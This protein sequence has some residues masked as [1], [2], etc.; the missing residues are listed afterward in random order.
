M[1]AS[2]SN[3]GGLR[4]GFCR[5]LIGFL[6][7]T[8]IGIF[9]AIH[10]TDANT[11]ADLIP[12][13]FKPSDFIP[14]WEDFFHEDPFNA[15]GPD[16]APRWRNSGN[17]LNLEIVNALDERWNVY[18][19]RAVQEWDA[20][21]PDVLD[22]TTS[23]SSVDSSCQAVEGVMKVCNGNY[24][25]TRWKGIN[26]VIIENG[27]RII[28]STAKMNEFYLSG[29]NDAQKQYTMCHEI[30]HGFG[31]P[32]TDENFNNANTGECMDYTSQ[33][34]ANMQ[35]GEANFLFLQE[36][37]GTQTGGNTVASASEVPTDR[38]IP[39]LRGSATISWFE[40]V[41]LSVWDDLIPKIEGRVDEREHEDGWQ[42]VH[43]S[44]HGSAHEMYLGKGLVVRVHKLFS[45][46]RLE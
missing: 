20:G 27:V 44:L 2:N 45:S 41:V 9:L 21:N 14:N 32:H 19:D 6:A 30:G 8:G 17:G 24:G 40:D 15:T 43:R 36:M 35:P 33:P 7:L 39:A 26:E 4:C 34:E 31:L 23:A 29:G 1:G 11:P 28:S 13:N 18:F 12:N 5:C 16:D 10:L 25:D 37:Y 3:G 22:L 38:R 42:L 46:E